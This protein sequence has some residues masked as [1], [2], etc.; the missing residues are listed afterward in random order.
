MTDTPPVSPP[1][2]LYVA[3]WNQNA[4]V[5]ENLAAT[6]TL[7]VALVIL[8]S[9]SPVRDLAH[10][11][12]SNLSLQRHILYQK[13]TPKSMGYEG[14]AVKKSPKPVFSLWRTIPVK[15]KIKKKEGAAFAAPPISKRYE[16]NLSIT[17]LKKSLTLTAVYVKT[18]MKRKKE[19]PA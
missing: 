4:I 12:F 16:H 14:V 2:E 9:V 6:L 17:F 15:H 5:I 1:L 19:I 7:L 13:F 8:L 11:V 18:Y 10:I 3:G